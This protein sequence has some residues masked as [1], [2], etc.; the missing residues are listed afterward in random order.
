MP[1]GRPPWEESLPR[2]RRRA[3]AE[4]VRGLAPWTWWIAVTF[5]GH[6]SRN[7]AHRA[8]RV[9]LSALARSH[10]EHLPVAWALEPSYINGW[11]AHVLLACGGATITAREI[12]QA[13]KSAH[14]RA[15]I[16]WLRRYNAR[17]GDPTRGAA[18]YLV[19][20]GE[21]DVNVACPRPPPCRR[22]AGCREAPG[23]WPGTT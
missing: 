5:T 19:K 22:R 13:W 23:P 16:P 14:T 15:G 18:D 17:H 1:I 10:G 9:W 8:L 3:A 11:H 20:G 21:W 12:E 4:F 7:T 2:R 6:V